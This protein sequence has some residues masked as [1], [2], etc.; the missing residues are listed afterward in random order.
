MARPKTFDRDEVL[1]R[2]MRVFW[3]QGYEATSIQDLVCATGINRA[4][5]YDT[6]GDKRGLF[7]ASV[8]R[9]VN[10]I[11]AMRLGALDEPGPAL[12]ALRRFFDDLVR[13]SVGEGR[14]LGCLMT[15]TSV[16]LAPHDEEVADLMGQ[17]LGRVEEAFFRLLTR[18]EAQSEISPGRD[19]RALARFLLVTLNGL[20]VL[21]RAKPEEAALRDVVET[22]LGAVEGSQ[23]VA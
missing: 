3:R 15:N 23:G 4:S 9:Y 22:A 17:A 13:F 12:P 21:A 7:L 5:M 2:A 11:S 20:R 14:R 16:E 19:L 8:D 1:D 6:F 10:A 18:A